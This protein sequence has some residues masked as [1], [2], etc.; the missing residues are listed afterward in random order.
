MS[1]QLKHHKNFPS[2][3]IKPRNVDVWLPPGYRADSKKRFG[4]LYMHDGQNLFYKQYSDSGEDWGIVP[5]MEKLIAAGE[6]PEVIIVGIWNTDRRLAEYLPQRPFETAQGQKAQKKLPPDFGN[7]IL[8]DSY[9]RFLVEELKPFIDGEY[10]TVGS[11]EHTSVMGSSMGGLV[12]LYASCQ[13][14][15]VFSGAGCVSTHWP[16]V[17]GV[18]LDY[19]KEHLPQPGHHRIYYDY[20]TETL[21]ALYEPHQLKVDALMRESGYQGEKDWITRRFEGAEH[22]E[23]AWRERVHIPLT[24]LLKK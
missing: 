13:Y 21:D 15:D 1:H 16:A 17:D 4:V 11:R 3:F 9:L 5:A 12:S 10:R 20:G 18:M 6:V 24:F 7:T 8:S 19:L 22:S 14:P 2:A 23:S